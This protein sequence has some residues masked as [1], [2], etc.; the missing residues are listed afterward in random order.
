MEATPEPTRGELDPRVVILQAESGPT[1]EV[2][3]LPADAGVGASFQ[4]GGTS[5][6]VTDRRTHGRVLICRRIES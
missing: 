1:V 4:Y 6:R 3:D 5:W 2:L